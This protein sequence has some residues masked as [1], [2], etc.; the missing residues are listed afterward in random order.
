MTD[1]V[2]AADGYSYDKAAITK[3]LAGSSISPMTGDTLPS[4]AVVPNWN[5]RTAIDRWRS[6][7]ATA[8]IGAPGHE[9]D[10]AQPKANGPKSP[11]PTRLA[12][13]AGVATAPRGGSVA[14]ADS[15]AHDCV[16]KPEP[17]APPP[18]S[19][20]V[21]PVKSGKSVSPMPSAPA[22]AG[23]AERLEQK[24]A[25]DTLG[26]IA[27]LTT[28]VMSHGI[29]CLVATDDEDGTP[30]EGVSDEEGGSGWHINVT[31]AARRKDEAMLGAILVLAAQRR[32][33]VVWLS[34]TNRHLVGAVQDDLKQLRSH[35]RALDM[36]SRLERCGDSA[37]LRL[38]DLPEHLAPLVATVDT[39]AIH[40]AV[41]NRQHDAV[42]AR[43]DELWRAVEAYGFLTL[44]NGVGDKVTS[45]GGGLQVDVVAAVSANDTALL[46]A[47][48]VL[49]SHD[50]GW[51]VWYHRSERELPP[52]LRESLSALVP[53]R[54]VLDLHSKLQLC[55]VGLSRVSA[56]PEALRNL[57]HLAELVD[58]SARLT[59]R[60]SAATASRVDAFKTRLI[61]CGHIVLTWVVDSC[62]R[63]GGVDL[64]RV[65]AGVSL[66]GEEVS[67]AA[68]VAANDK[69]SLE[70]LEL[71]RAR[72]ELVVW[73]WSTDQH[74]ALDAPRGAGVHPA[75]VE[76]C[77]RLAR[78][79]STPLPP[80]SA[81]DENEAWA[82]FESQI[83][84]KRAASE[85]DALNAIV[86]RLLSSGVG[87]ALVDGSLDSDARPAN[88]AGP[89][90]LDAAHL[91]LANDVATLWA[92]ARVRNV[93]PRL[94]RWRSQADSAACLAL[95]SSTELPGTHSRAVEAMNELIRPPSGDAGNVLH[96][97][98]LGAALANFSADSDLRETKVTAQLEAALLDAGALVLVSRVSVSHDHD[99]HADTV[100]SNKLSQV[101]LEREDRT[102]EATIRR[103]EAGD[104]CSATARV[105]PHVID[106]FGAVWQ[107]DLDLLRGLV[108]V[109]QNAA[110][111]DVDWQTDADAEFPRW[112]ESKL[113]DT[114]VEALELARHLGATAWSRAMYESASQRL[115]ALLDEIRERHGQLT[116]TSSGQSR[117]G[118]VFR[119]V[120]V[121]DDESQPLLGVSR[122]QPGRA[123]EFDVVTVA[124]NN[125]TL[126]VETLLSI[127]RRDEGLVVWRDRGDRQLPQLERNLT[128]SGL[129]CDTV[130]A[131]RALGAVVW[132]CADNAATRKKSTCCTVLQNVVWCLLYVCC[133]CL[134]LGFIAF[135]IGPL[136]TDD[137]APWMIITSVTNGICVLNEVPVNLVN[138]RSITRRAPYFWH[139]RGVFGF[140]SLVIT[141]EMIFFQN[142]K[143]HNSTHAM[144]L[145]YVAAFWTAYYLLRM[146]LAKKRRTPEIF[147]LARAGDVEE[148]ERCILRGA[149]VNQANWSNQTPLHIAAMRKGGAGSVK[150]LLDHNADVNHVDYYTKTPLLLAVI[151]RNPDSVDILLDGGANPMA[152]GRVH[153][154][155]SIFVKSV[156]SYEGPLLCDECC[157]NGSSLEDRGEDGRRVVQVLARHGV[158]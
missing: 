150:C 124:H 127:Q 130:P 104:G 102:V 81:R 73:R 50:K 134:I 108:A 91:L 139:L 65:R 21:P 12:G 27:E 5:L 72:C 67:V 115:V 29:I 151:F 129:P 87:I 154:T 83:D 143:F 111:G 63:G 132:E 136:T 113:P 88:A 20:E 55:E 141:I 77:R 26:R 114:H 52:A 59:E 103:I 110:A 32:G 9:A 119:G 14:G 97:V 18:A 51:V 66:T 23:L 33:W 125:D 44:C 155:L 96:G 25:T 121:Q 40:A 137:A 101:L 126:L 158:Q 106:V 70:A 61:D 48:V 28:R 38:V 53:Y 157:N 142:F 34:N 11:L 69:P 57:G 64:P 7:A 31:D 58:L 152:R 123:A 24:R 80:P 39:A 49:A 68:L 43:F 1:P 62:G 76:L 74:S 46:G 2:S 36:L 146:W 35:R 17:S 79:L 75:T 128:D 93:R 84:E 71:L 47:I 156:K 148:L 54:H 89:H 94:V 92:L 116:L 98:D 30:S 135:Y 153:E 22:A 8:A 149:D 41:A 15:D 10:Y 60:A 100:G 95:T 37:D 42:V 105:E 45:A 78:P 90:V 56:I 107:N 16:A 122:G 99:H 112:L 138:H 118:N 133:T 86:R 131:I 120:H 4:T 109:Q 147:K 144:W 6:G 117:P 82:M 13:L 3:W 140:F 19:V 145:L 85:H